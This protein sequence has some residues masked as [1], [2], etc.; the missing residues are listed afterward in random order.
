MTDPRTEQLTPSREPTRWLYFL[1]S[2]FAY[3]VATLCLLRSLLPNFTTHVAGQT[4]GWQATWN[5]WWVYHNVVETQHF[6]LFY[7]DFLYYPTGAALLFHTYN[8]PNGF[9]ALPLTA[10]V[11]PLVANNVLLFASFVATGWAAYALARTLGL[12]YFAAWLAG[13]VYTFANPTRW[14]FLGGGQTF[15]LAMQWMPLYILALVKLTSPPVDAPLRPRLRWLLAAA[16][17]LVLTAL[18]DWQFFVYMGLFTIMFIVYLLLR[19]RSWRDRLRATRDVVLAG[20]T[21]VAV[22]SPLLFVTVREAT[23]NASI[24]RP[25]D[26]TLAHSWDLTSFVT[27]NAVS[28]LYGSIA[29][30]F[31]F[32]GN[33]YGDVP[34][35]S[36]AGYVA[37]GLALV[38]LVACWRQ[39]RFWAAADAGGAAAG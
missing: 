19:E 2:P 31:D 30:S 4:D 32:V 33:R 6:S 5:I 12:G 7:T 38:G 34:G 16:L 17:F 25:F 9:F 28:P 18:A 39:T 29:R 1:A 20:L 24:V 21:A 22:L 37:M 36:N 3:L 23:G 10:T 26:Q 8:V 13:A 35:I 14:N 27:P 15:Y 11:G